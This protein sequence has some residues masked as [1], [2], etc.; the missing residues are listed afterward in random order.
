MSVRIAAAVLCGTALTGGVATSASA[1]DSGHP[2]RGELVAAVPLSGLD[3]EQV[4]GYLAK[5]GL[6]SSRVRF[7]VDATRIVYRTVDPRGAQTT[8]SALV[9]L[10]RNE[11]R[12]PRQVTWLYGTTGYR[13][14]VASVSDGNDRAA[15]LLFASA[16]YLT[17]AP[18]YLGLGVGPGFHPYADARSTVTAS[19]D[20]LRATQRFA[21]QNGLRPDPRVL[22]TGHSQGGHATM[23]L[24][25]SL[26]RGADP[27]LGLGGLAPISGPMRLSRAVADALAGEIDNATAYLAYWTVAW[28]RLYD[29]YDS[30]AEAFLDPSIEA[31]FDGNHPNEEIFPRL[32]ATVTEL[33]T[34]AYLDRLRQ[35]TGVLR[36]AL[37]EADSYC[38]WRP[39]VPVTLY[40]STGDRD[41]SISNS[42]YCLQRL[43]GQHADATLI[44]LGPDVDHSEAARLALP[45]VLTGFDRS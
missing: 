23:A 45:R 42:T 9:A 38:D 44:D 11:N 8:A 18:D 27:R 40:T 3:R 25:R 16:G 36:T 6:D 43:E 32:P 30:P 31:L 7:G 34:P 21:R 4:A 15:A 28:N 5:Y 14:S 2:S 13:G 24:G 26:Q 39:R 1:N 10:P 35:P 22:V 29:L 33:F 19:V 12:S 20:A 17:S 37:R 41:V